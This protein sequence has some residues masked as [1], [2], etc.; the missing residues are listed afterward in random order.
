MLFFFRG[1][2]GP[3]ARAVVGAAF[4]AIGLAVHAGDIYIAAG[5]AFLAWAG[6]A[7]IHAVRVSRDDVYTG[8]ESA[9]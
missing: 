9:R 8:G 6:L 3:A 5:I 4:L 7:Q 1:R 2:Y